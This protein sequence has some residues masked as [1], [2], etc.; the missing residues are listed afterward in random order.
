MTKRQNRPNNGLES[1]VPDT[2]Q[3]DEERTATRPGSFT[4]DHPPKV[5]EGAPEEL[6]DSS[7]QEDRGASDALM[8][9]YNG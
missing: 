3:Q 9:S 1:P 4:A 7:R 6:S 2:R 8:E 5:E